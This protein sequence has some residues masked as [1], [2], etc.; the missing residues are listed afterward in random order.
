MEDH[1]YLYDDLF[2]VVGL[3]DASGAL[4]ERYEYADYGMPAVYDAANNPLAASAFQNA[5]LFN[6][7]RYD[8]ATGLYYY[9]TR[10]MDPDLGRFISRDTIGLWGDEANLGNPYAFAFIPET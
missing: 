7:R 4:R 5:Y 2:N 6:G 9:R 10:Y 1:Y 8:A 3:A